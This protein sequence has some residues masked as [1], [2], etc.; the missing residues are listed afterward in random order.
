MI[1]AANTPSTAMTTSNSIMV[2]PNA[3]HPRI[4]KD[5]EAGSLLSALT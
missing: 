3:G 5:P 1:A 2:K 4:R